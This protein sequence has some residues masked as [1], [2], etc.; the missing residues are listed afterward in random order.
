[1]QQNV[2]VFIGLDQ[3]GQ[4]SVVEYKSPAQC[5]E[6]FSLQANE[7]GD[8]VSCGTLKCMSTIHHRSVPL[9]RPYEPSGHTACGINVI[10]HI[11]TVW[12]AAEAPVTCLQCREVLA[13]TAR[14]QA[15]AIL[16]RNVREE[17]ISEWWGR[18]I[19]ALDGM[20]PEQM[21]TI[22]PS[23]VVELIRRIEV[24]GAS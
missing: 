2:A 10:E 12:S 15:D 22:E 9:A 13:D 1:M 7:T 18:E 24:T 20:T 11:D 21:L 17:A 16:A 5:T 8:T 3:N 19:E 4:K 23:R 14:H 6:A